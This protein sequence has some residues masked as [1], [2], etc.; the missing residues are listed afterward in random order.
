[1][2]VQI[3]EAIRGSGL[4]ISELSRKCGVSQPQ[5]SRF[6][7]GER[8]L[9]LPAAARVCETLGM[10]LTGPKATRQSAPDQPEHPKPRGRKSTEK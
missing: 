7:N 5:I 4:S 1:M 2:V 8:T 6:V 3:R 10:R 9:T